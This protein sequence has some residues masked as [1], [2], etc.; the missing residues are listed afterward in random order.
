VDRVAL[1]VRALVRSETHGHVVD[2]DLKHLVERFLDDRNLVERTDLFD[3]VDETQQRLFLLVAAVGVEVIRQ[4]PALGVGRAE[5]NAAPTACAAD[6]RRALP[7][8][9]QI[10][11]LE[12]EGPQQRLALKLASRVGHGDPP[13]DR[14][15]GPR[16]RRRA[17]PR[18][19]RTRRQ[20]RH[21]QKLAPFH[22][23][24]FLFLA[25]PS[26]HGARYS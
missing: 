1:G 19:R 10:S 9:G 26:F 23:L 16:A 20:R 3:V 17:P 15:R 24:P 12:T 18:R 14:L 13:A 22:G 25:H 6:H 5:A 21:L 7:D 4:A 11:A 8:V 2:V